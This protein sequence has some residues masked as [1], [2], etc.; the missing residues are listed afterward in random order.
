MKLA[1]RD[2]PERLRTDLN[3]SIK[4][5]GGVMKFGEKDDYPN[6]IEKVVASSV[7]ATATAEIFAKF[8]TGGGFEQP[9]LNDM[10]IGRDVRGKELR[11]LDLLRLF[12]QSVSVF[13][14]IYVHL[15]MN[16]DGQIEDPK[17]MNFKHCRFTKLDDIG[18]T[19]S[20]AVN[21][22]FGSGEKF[23]QDETVEYSIFNN[24]ID[25]VRAQIKKAGT[26]EDYKG[27]MYFQFW[28]N[29]YL[30]PL[31]PYDPVY[32]DA[33]TE[34][35]VS[36]YKN[37]ELR[38]GFMLRYLL[39]IAEFENEKNKQDFLN[40]IEGAEGADG[41]RVI[42]LEDEVDETTN[43]I[44][45]SGAFKL[46]KIDSSINDKLF[47]NWETSLSNKIRKANKALPA[48]LIDYETSALGNTSGEAV[49]QAVAFYNG[50][51]KDDRTLMSRVFSEIFK[52]HKDDKISAI[53]NWDIAPLSLEEQ[54]EEVIEVGAEQKN[55]DA[56]AQ[57]RGSVGGVT[58]LIALQQSVAAKTSTIESA[59]A[60][61]EIIYG[62][63][64][65]QAQKMIGQPVET[66]P[67]PINPV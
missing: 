15:P 17:M 54:T 59:I 45:D 29:R 49:K 9:G 16:V 24:S 57:L 60:V 21:K 30:Y 33:D 44:K 41:L 39:R 10:V 27:Q 26:I 48:I 25:V 20:I 2:V 58:A 11:M 50:M 13:N 40:M 67:E 28:D 65:E 3:K 61:L 19:N 55:A 64:T 8:L 62:V 31:S 23:K 18:Y 51:T 46:E 52:H 47:E 36:L 14:G 12:S 53:T 63:T 66:P 56:Q 42:V 38:N 37:R 35:Q 22:K 7:T 43:Q 1:N 5:G 32:L 4:V 6:V 34:W